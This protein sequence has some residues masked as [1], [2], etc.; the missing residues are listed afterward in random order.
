MENGFVLIK[1]ETLQ[2]LLDNFY[3]VCCFCDEM[4]I[5]E[6]EE[7]DDDMQEMK[8]WAKEKFGRDINKE[9]YE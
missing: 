6:C 9:T 4:D 2:Q 7:L 8:K 3:E 1:K 5:Y